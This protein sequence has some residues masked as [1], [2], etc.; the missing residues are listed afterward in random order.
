MS[1]Q[2]AVEF[3]IKEFSD[4]I[5]PLDTKPM[6]DLL[7]MDAMKR[8]KAME[9][10]QIINAYIEGCTDAYGVDEPNPNYP[11]S[12]N[13]KDY[14]NQTYGG[15]QIVLEQILSSATILPV[16]ESWE[17]LP[18]SFWYKDNSERLYPN[19]VIIQPKQ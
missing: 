3:L 11:D 7:M 8:A 16:E 9:K 17:D 10:E 14:Y 5:G 18:L 2:T 12:E 4:I 19:G 15:K 13:A 1:K 6:Q